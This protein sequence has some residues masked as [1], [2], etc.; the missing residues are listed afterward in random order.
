MCGKVLEVFLYLHNPSAIKINDEEVAS[1]WYE[2]TSNTCTKRDT[3]L[4]TASAWQQRR[5]SYFIIS[6][7]IQ[8]MCETDR[9][10]CTVWAWQQGQCSDLDCV[11][12]FTNKSSENHFLL[13]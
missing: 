9:E 1:S 7:S 3:E 4:H 10:V 12:I 11:Q 2:L 8:Y 13:S 6:M 5:I